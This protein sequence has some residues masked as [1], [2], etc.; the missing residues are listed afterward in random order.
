MS[1]GCLLRWWSGEKERT[2][3]IAC[4][5]HTDKPNA[6][7]YLFLLALRCSKQPADYADVSPEEGADCDQFDADASL[8]SDFLAVRERAR[9]KGPAVGKF[10]LRESDVWHC[11][12]I[13]N[14]RGAALICDL[15]VSRN[16]L[17]AAAAW[18]FEGNTGT[19]AV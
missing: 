7:V 14:R 8:R 18:Q 5:D 1:I 10:A 13:Q 15:P 2:A 16:R 19:I 12:Y 3:F 9:A 4:G 6:H 17:I 11:A